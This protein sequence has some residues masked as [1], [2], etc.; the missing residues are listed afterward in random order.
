[1]MDVCATDCTWGKVTAI[2]DAVDDHGTYYETPWA[3]ALTI[4]IQPAP[5]ADDGQEPESED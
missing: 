5:L 1:M 2:G 3:F 4:D